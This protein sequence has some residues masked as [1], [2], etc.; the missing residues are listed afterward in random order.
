MLRV[1][2]GGVKQCGG[3]RASVCGLMACSHVLPHPLM[4]P[5]PPCSKDI[6]V[7]G[8]LGPASALEKKSPLVSDQVGRVEAGV[9]GGNAL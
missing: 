4:R 7:C 5:P 1:D 9:R 6:K 2:G 8:L 3:F